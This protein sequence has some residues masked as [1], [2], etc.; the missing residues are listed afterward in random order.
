[1][2]YVS[3]VE[4]FL[5]PHHTLPV[6]LPKNIDVDFGHDQSHHKL[7]SSPSLF[8]AMIDDFHHHD[9]KINLPFLRTVM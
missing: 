4:S 3:V 2:L 9:G 5:G 8:Q 7:T 1:V 6:A